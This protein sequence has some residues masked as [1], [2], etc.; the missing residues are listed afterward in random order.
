MFRAGELTLDIVTTLLQRTTLITDPAV[1]TLVDATL[2]GAA[3]RLM[4]L[5]YGQV[6]GHVD[7]V[8]AKH[9]RDAVRRRKKAA[10]EREVW[11]STAST[12]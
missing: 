8:I 9:D 12:E 11:S 6:C 10:D 4:R 2:A 1:L 7:R 3:A 5:S